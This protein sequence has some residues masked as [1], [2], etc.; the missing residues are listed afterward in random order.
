MKKREIKQGDIF[1]CDLSDGAIDSEQ[2]NCRPILI[3]SLYLRNSTSP[4]IFIFPITSQSTKR[5]QPTHYKLF[6]SDYPF[7][8]YD[9]NIV[10][11][12]EGRSISKN[13]IHSLIGHISEL[14]FEN[15]LKCKEYVFIKKTT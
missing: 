15:I 9:E 10:L 1:M 4:N 2:K 8:I 11:C 6:K 14:D 12:E 13:R 7:F 5:F 3:A